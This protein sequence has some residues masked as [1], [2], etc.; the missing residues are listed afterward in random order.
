LRK[1]LLNFIITDQNPIVKEMHSHNPLIY[2]KL[3][4]DEILQQY[5]IMGQYAL[6]PVSTASNLYA[7]IIVGKIG[8]DQ[9]IVHKELEKLML[10]ANTVG[11]HLENLNSM[12]NLERSVE[13][14]TSELEI[15]NRLLSTS[16]N[17][18]DTMLKLVSHD[19]NAPLRNV[20][21]LVESI[22][23]RY[24]DQLDSDL[25]DRLVRIR[26][27]IE[28]ELNMIDEILTSFRTDESL[29]LSQHIDIRNLIQSILDELAFE[30]KRKNVKVLMDKSLPETFKSNQT[31][32][33]HIFLNLI[34]NACKYMP[35][36][37]S[38]NEIQISFVKDDASMIFRVSDNGNGIPK[39]KQDFIFDSY[40]KA[41]TSPDE[42]GGKGLGLALVK[43]MVGK[44][45]GEISFSSKENKGTTF[46]IRFNNL[47]HQQENL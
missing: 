18:K 33:K 45:K 7:M 31:I 3:P 47:N 12:A 17:E 22:Q 1:D 23:R 20:I 34:D 24:K 41:V 4:F 35:L 46:F 5:N 9:E 29:D 38:G 19:L 43:N 36:K 16:I 11:L 27:N 10:L 44:I 32:M 39:E 42:S 30:L 26:K 2:S 25:S 37:N 40:Q 21:G 13:K 15:T 8:E 28:K 6:V 14:R